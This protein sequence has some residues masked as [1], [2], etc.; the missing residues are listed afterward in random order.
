MD[1]D[2]ETIRTAVVIIIKA[3][4]LVLQFSGRI[5]KRKLMQL[6]KMDIDDKSKEIIFLRDKVHQLKTR[7]TIFQK[8]MQANYREVICVPY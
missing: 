1:K 2:I 8:V 7:T 4:V 5:R 6:A 3:A